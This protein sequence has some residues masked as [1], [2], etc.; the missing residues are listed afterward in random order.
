M[1]F[2]TIKKGEK[3]PKTSCERNIKK[4]KGT[5][6]TLVKTIMVSTTTKRR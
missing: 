2:M 3:K 1:G 4:R 6:K 5:Q